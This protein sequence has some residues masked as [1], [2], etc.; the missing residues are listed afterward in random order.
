MLT[1]CNR[2]IKTEASILVLE[3]SSSIN[4]SVLYMLLFVVFIL[5]RYIHMMDG[6]ICSDTADHNAGKFGP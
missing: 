5:L 3:I 1:A 4:A 2:Q 6:N